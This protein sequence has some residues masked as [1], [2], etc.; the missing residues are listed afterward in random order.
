MA[1]RI[2]SIIQAF[3]HTGDLNRWQAQELIAE[4]HR[5]RKLVPEPHP[6]V[7]PFHKIIA[8]R[9]AKTGK[10]PIIPP[11]VV[12]EAMQ[13][14]VERRSKL[15]R[16]ALIEEGA[17]P[18]H[19]DALNDPSRRLYAETLPPIDEDILERVRRRVDAHE[20]DEPFSIPL[21]QE[22]Q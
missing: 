4:I 6:K 20:F 14:H 9:G 3:E 8:F 19:V 1:D 10:I 22:D 18:D 12:N 5:L 2:D 7:D 13:M 15:L 11:S 17:N 21:P 16:N